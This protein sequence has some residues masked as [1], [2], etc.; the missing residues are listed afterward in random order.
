VVTPFRVGPT[1]DL[2]LVAVV[3]DGEL[4]VAAPLPREL[5]RA[6]VEVAS[7]LGLADD[8]LNAGL[9]QLIELGLP[10]GYE[11]R[12]VTRRFAGLTVHLAGRFAIEST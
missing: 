8:W 7:L 6:S 10:A 2:D 11:A 9:T 3:R 1:E 4:A 12:V 5:A